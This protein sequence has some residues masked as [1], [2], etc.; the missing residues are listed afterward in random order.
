MVYDKLFGRNKGHEAIRLYGTLLRWGKRSGLANRNSETPLEYGRR[1][2]QQFNA[3]AAEIDL[4][5]FSFNLHVY[6]EMVC[7]GQE[8]AHARQALK[9][10]QSPMLW[11]KRFKLWFFSSG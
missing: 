4:I 8:V 3:V 6:G 2:K 10:L 5:I 7:E 1:L 11:P 9:R